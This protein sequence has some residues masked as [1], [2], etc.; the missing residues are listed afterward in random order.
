MAISRIHNS[1]RDSVACRAGGDSRLESFA[2]SLSSFWIR[3]L[4]PDPVDSPP[5]IGRG[6]LPAPSRRM[7]RRVT[8]LRLLGEER[9]ARAR[10]GRGPR[11][12]RL[13]P[14]RVIE[15]ALSSA[16][17]S[18]SIMKRMCGLWVDDTARAVQAQHFLGQL[19]LAQDQLIESLWSFELA[20]SAE[21]GDDERRRCCCECESGCR[22][23]SGPSTAGLPVS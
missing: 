13:L 18:R 22:P 3:P 4:D 9:S 7:V 14:R 12:R 19:L 11:A 16:K 17:V 8:S 1:P 6:R 20:M 10:V 2:R 21:P 5:A 23:R 15:F